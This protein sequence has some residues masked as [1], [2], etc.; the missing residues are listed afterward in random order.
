[1]PISGMK[2]PLDE[3]TI[4]TYLFSHG[5]AATKA[6]AYGYTKKNPLN[7]TT[8]NANHIID[9]EN[10]I[11]VT[12]DYPDA[13]E[14]LIYPEIRTW[15]DLLN[16]RK[17]LKKISYR[18]DR[19]NTDFAGEKERTFLMEQHANIKSNAV[20]G[21]G[22]SRGASAFI[23]GIGTHPDQVAVE[24]IKAL[25]LESP[26]DSMDSI[27]RNIIGEYL[28][29]YPAARSLGHNL[30]RFIF[31]QYKKR[32]TSPL[33]AAKN[34]PLDLPI[35][36]ICSEQDTRVPASSSE[37]LYDELIRTGHDKAHFVKLTRGVHGSLIQ[38]PDGETYRNAV[39]AFYKKYG[40]DHNAEYAELGK[41]SIEPK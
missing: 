1:M 30:I 10:H 6:Q 4:H 20:I 19:A 7:A 5:L 28:Y 23:T 12:F 39:H 9:N 18:V 24:N 33:E 31:S 21:V 41:D 2:Q 37:K 27:L 17:N 35:L 32:A 25:V 11:L 36:I 13:G 34:V 38:G 26:F 14:S 15:Y 16:L 40:L 29:Q 22:V 3:E 8:D